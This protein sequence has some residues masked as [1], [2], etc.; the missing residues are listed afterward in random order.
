M[1]SKRPYAGLYFL[2]EVRLGAQGDGMAGRRYVR[3]TFNYGHSRR[4][5]A[6]PSSAKSRMRQAEDATKGPAIESVGWSDWVLAM[7]ARIAT[8]LPMGT[9]VMAIKPDDVACDRLCRN[10]HW[11]RS[12]PGAAS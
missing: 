10:A 5:G 11:H 2:D 3:S 6:G 7:H 8:V 4:P 12:C 9:R 1:G